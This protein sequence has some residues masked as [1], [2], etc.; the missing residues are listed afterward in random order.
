M[1]SN[2]IREIRE[3]IDNYRGT[4]MSLLA[5]ANEA[6]WNKKK[7][8]FIEGSQFSLGRAMNTSD[9]NRVSPK[10]RVTPDLIVQRT[11]DYGIVCEAKTCLPP[12]SD[13]KE[14]LA[15]YEEC[16]EQIAKYDDDLQ[17]WLTED[18]RIP[19]HDLVLLVDQTR[20]VP[21]KRF[22]Q[23]HSLVATL[24]R[25]FAVVSTAR[26]SQLD[27]FVNLRKEYGSLTETTLDQSLE[28]VCSVSIKHL[29]GL[30]AKLKFYDAPPP[31]PVYTVQIL[32]DHVFLTLAD[33][34]VID[35]E[36]KH[37]EIEV[38]STRLCELLQ[39]LYGTTGV[40]SRDCRIPD[41]VW[42]EEALDFLVETG[43]AKRRA[44]GTYVITYPLRRRGGGDTEGYFA[45]KAVQIT[46]RKE[47]QNR[48]ER[49]KSGD[50]FEQAN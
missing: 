50:L 3:S 35:A 30:L 5:F 26:T 24:G 43:D 48:A 40:D 31:T 49:L 44:D 25:K 39:K 28:D 29:E 32:W 45:R 10:E 14:T 46:R 12:L 18:E 9:Q 23:S 38:D 34:D 19:V 16:V 41:K 8:Q 6:R 7:G 15:R 13:K 36:A 33:P 17:G 1:S 37:C 22:V 20:G 21:M 47:M 2:K 11:S 42:V 4:I 27:D